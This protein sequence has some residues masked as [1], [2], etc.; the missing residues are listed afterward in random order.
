VFDTR[1]LR[2]QNVGNNQHTNREGGAPVGDQTNLYV[3]PKIAP[4][5]W[6]KVETFVRAAVADS[7]PHV[8]YSAAQLTRY[9]GALAAW[10]VNIAGHPLDRDVVFRREVIGEFVARGGPNYASARSARSALLRM[11]EVLVSPHLRVA[12]LAPLPK[13]PPTRPYSLTNITDIRSWAT[14][15]RTHYAR[16]QAQLL[17]SLGFGAGL[18]A[19]EITHLRARDVTVDAGGVLVQVREG[20]GNPR[21]VPVLAEWEQSLADYARLGHTNPDAYVFAPRRNRRDKNTTFAFLSAND[22]PLEVRRMRVTWIVRHLALGKIPIHVFMD[23]AGLDSLT[24]L[25]RYV[26]FLPVYEPEHARMLLRGA[27]S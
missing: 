24:G 1:P 14:G 23:A 25:S 21:F 15:L 22:A 18:T 2:E 13:S 8:K 6:A 19:Q 3:P 20:S 9:A 10:C 11:S 7:E 26:E 27:T 16:T 4:S 17:M 12:Q 5:D